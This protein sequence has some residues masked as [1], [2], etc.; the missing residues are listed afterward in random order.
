MP[1]FFEERFRSFVAA[2]YNGIPPEQLPVRQRLEIEDAFMSGASVGFMQGFGCTDEEAVAASAELGEF[3]K[4]IV[5]R[6]KDAGLIKD[7]KNV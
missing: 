3:G 4:R 5:Q 6:Y 2:Q 7:G 1:K